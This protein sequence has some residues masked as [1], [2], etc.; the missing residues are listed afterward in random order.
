MKLYGWVFELSDVEALQ[1]SLRSGNGLLPEQTH[2][3]RSYGGI[4]R[5]DPAGR[6]YKK[7]GRH[8]ACPYEYY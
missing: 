7:M 5:G 1:A 8:K 6:L 3:Y 4:Y 2:P